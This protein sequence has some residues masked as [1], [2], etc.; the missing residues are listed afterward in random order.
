MWFR[1]QKWVAGNC[2]VKPET[3]RIPL[4]VRIYNVPLEAWNLE[5]ISR[6]ASRIGTPLIMDKVTTA[7]CDKGYGRASYARVL[8]EIDDANGL[9][10]QVEIWYR[11][12]NRSMCLKV[13]YA[14][15]P[16]ICCAHL[17]PLY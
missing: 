17:C 14:W 10:D 9:V 13:E 4:W 2:L 6:I 8:V 11:N 12:L 15:K 5:G 3:N 1:T 16:P 7:M